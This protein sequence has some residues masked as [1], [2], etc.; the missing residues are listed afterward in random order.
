MSA[1]WLLKKN[2]WMLELVAMQEGSPTHWTHLS[3]RQDQWS[4]AP[5]CQ[6][7]CIWSQ[8][9]E[10]ITKACV[11]YTISTILFVWKRQ[12]TMTLWTRL[13]PESLHEICI[14]SLLK[15]ELAWLLC[16]CII[17]VSPKTFLSTLF[18][19]F[20]EIKMAFKGECFQEDNHSLPF[21]LSRLLESFHIL[22]S[23]ERIHSSVQ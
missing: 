7:H 9:F 21:A 4:F 5:L 1:L 15:L 8:K 18:L 19:A 16:S 17:L 12:I 10:Q 13:W 14:N 6:P 2:L 11:S 20:W 3:N 22:V 23:P